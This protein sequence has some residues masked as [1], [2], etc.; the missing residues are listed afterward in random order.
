MA[1]DWAILL[2][3]KKAD[4]DLVKSRIWFLQ[5]ASPKSG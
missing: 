1:D 5:P 2:N 3:K 4:E